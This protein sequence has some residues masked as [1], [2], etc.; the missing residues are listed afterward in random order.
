MHHGLAKAALLIL[1]ISPQ[2][3]EIRSPYIG[4]ELTEIT[5]ERFRLMVKVFLELVLGLGLAKYG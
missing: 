1:S 2:L 5:Q 4:M 3:M